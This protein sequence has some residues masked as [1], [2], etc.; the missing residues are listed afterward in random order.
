[1]STYLYASNAIST[2]DFYAKGDVLSS[3]IPI[4]NNRSLNEP[5]YKEFINPMLLRRMGKA[6]KMSVVCALKCLKN[7]EEIS[8]KAIIVGT[9][10]GAIIDT[11]KFLT[12]TSQIQSSILPPTSFIQSG[13]NS[14][15][16][17]IALLLKNDAYNMTHVQ[18]GVSFEYALKDAVL[19]VQEGAELT[20]VGA[21]DEHSQLLQYV[22]EKLTL[23][24]PI[25]DQLSSGAAFFSLGSKPKGAIAEIKSVVI[26]SST[27]VQE[28]LEQEL[29]KLNVQLSDLSLALIGDNLATTT[30]DDLPIKTLNYTNYTGR[31]FSSS[32]V[33]L[34]LA[35]QCL[36]QNNSSLQYIAVINVATKNKIGIT[37]IKRV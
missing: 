36:Q 5:I 10:L 17:Q 7:T 2:I 16:G 13:H 37:I 12:I 24:K 31:F 34:H 3:L 19:T 9:G 32:A 11:E 33:G 25:A 26:S 29:T 8:P 28:A 23:E 20:L 1:M 35:T 6:T 22:A 4:E 30:T 27:D 14:I 21:V 15:A 18:Q